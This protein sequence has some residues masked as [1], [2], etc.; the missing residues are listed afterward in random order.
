MT[1]PVLFRGARLIDPAS[2]LDESGDVRVEDGV[3]AEVGDSLPTDGAAALD[4]EGLTLAPALIDLCARVSAPGQARG[5]SV[6]SLSRAAA[7]GGVGT[8][9]IVGDHGAPIDTPDRVSGLLARGREGPIRVMAAGAMTR[10]R[11]LAEM[12]LMQRA[13]AAFLH[14]AED[15]FYLRRQAMAYAGGLDLLCSVRPEEAGFEDA[16]FWEGELA[17]RLGAASEPEAAERLAAERDLALAEL[18]GA[19]LM[20]DRIATREALEPLARAKAKGLE[21]FGSVGIAHLSFNE[22]D[23]GGLNPAFRLTPPLASEASRR[24]LVEAV[25]QGLIDA[26]VSDH[27]PRAPEEK[28]APF[29][30][31]AP[32]SANIE[33]LLSALL[34]LAADGQLTLLQALAPVTSGPASILGLKQGRIAE[35]APADLVLFDAEAPFVCRPEAMK[36]AARNTAYAGR[37]LHGQVRM[38]L[39]GGAMA[40]E[41]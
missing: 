30:E 3:I 11:A 24:A 5:E 41:G 39:V 14:G 9:A 31:A 38:T 21:V 34:A 17:A 27:S 35:G 7:A 16:L 26:V 10:E 28:D 25:A 12:G 36:S 23:A 4:C 18:T 6:A 15:G 37:R 2:T 8:I 29:G 40:F 22:I 19:R 33:V 1:R 32:G 13:G 20:L